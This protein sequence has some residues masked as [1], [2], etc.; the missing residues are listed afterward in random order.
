[1]IQYSLLGP[2]AVSNDL[3]DTFRGLA[4]SPS[5]GR[6]DITQYLSVVCLYTCRG[7]EYQTG[8]ECI[9]PLESVGGLF[10]L[11]CSQSLLRGPH[12][13]YYIYHI[14]NNVFMYLL[15]NIDSVYRSEMALL[16]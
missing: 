14:N 11:L 5:S 4:P 7:R 12:L 16:S 15:C 9:N 10:I 1:M 3:K 13:T 8:S 2:S 6:T